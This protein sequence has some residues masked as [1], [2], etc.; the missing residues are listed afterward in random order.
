ML[1]GNIFI[2]AAMQWSPKSYAKVLGRHSLRIRNNI[3]HCDPSTQKLLV[4]TKHFL[5]SSPGLTVVVP[6]KVP[7]LRAIF[8]REMVSKSFQN[9]MPPSCGDTL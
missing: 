3:M 4:Q 2:E 8:F 6:H 5:S 9:F 1:R 7:R